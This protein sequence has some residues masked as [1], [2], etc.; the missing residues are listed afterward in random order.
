MTE[1]AKT[2]KRK[3]KAKRVEVIDKKGNIA[4]PFEKD[5]E[6]WLGK[7]WT[8]KESAGNA[9]EPEAQG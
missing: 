4:R 7:G 8:V 1:E 3:A 2:T 5:L 6:A 9:E